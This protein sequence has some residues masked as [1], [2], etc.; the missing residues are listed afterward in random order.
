MALTSDEARIVAFYAGRGID[1]AGRSLDQVLSFDFARLETTHDYIQWLF[2]LPEP[3]AFNPAAPLL[4]QPVIDAFQSDPRLMARFR[5]ALER[6]LAFFGIALQVSVEGPKVVPGP[7]WPERQAHWV[8]ANNHNHLRLTRI[9]RSCH[10]LGLRAEATALGG[11]LEH[12]A[13]DNPGTVTLVTRAFW[14]RASRGL[15]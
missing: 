5:R 7:D 10:L 11:F 3:S 2:P 9:L 14:E 12:V 15:P 6:M 8:H 1:D 4:T 13:A